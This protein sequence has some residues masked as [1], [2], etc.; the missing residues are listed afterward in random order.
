MA[1]CPNLS[2]SETI[3]LIKRKY[4]LISLDKESKQ[5]DEKRFFEGQETGLK[6]ALFILGLHTGEGLPKDL[7]AEMI[8]LEEKDYAALRKAF[9]DIEGF[10]I[11]KD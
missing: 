8:H 1:R 6:F 3:K 10:F 11:K 4:E 2:L 7:F 9:S 5:G